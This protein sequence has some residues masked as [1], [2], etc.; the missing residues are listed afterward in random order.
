MDTP[1]KIALHLLAAAAAAAAGQPVLAVQQLAEAINDATDTPTP[2]PTPTTG[3][4][5]APQ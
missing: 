4:E 3:K 1:A 5:D 2:T